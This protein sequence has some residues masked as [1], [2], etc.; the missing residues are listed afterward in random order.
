M[1]IWF[2]VWRGLRLSNISLPHSR[3]RCRACRRAPVAAPA[4]G[5]LLVWL[6]LPFVVAV[7]RLRV[8]GAAL[9]LFCS[10]RGRCAAA[11]RGCRR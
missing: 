2:A 5:L 6:S 10:H 8:V 11:R 3:G 7:R 4:V 9:R 1:R